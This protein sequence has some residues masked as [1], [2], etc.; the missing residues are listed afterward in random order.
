MASN[1]QL[2][3][4]NGAPTAASVP[5]GDDTWDEAKYE[6]SLKHLHEL[7]LQLR[8]LR[9]TI[10]R[11][12][13][14][15]TENVVN[16]AELF[17]A[18]QQSMASGVKDVKDFKDSMSSRET[19]KIISRAYQSRQKN[20]LQIKPWRPKDDSNWAQMDLD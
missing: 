2:A 8:R 4:L 6:A 12:I 18:L 19:N 14:P 10:P 11:M 16:P 15:A 3:R 20:P 9:A 17:P 7:H 5:A 13:A 1:P